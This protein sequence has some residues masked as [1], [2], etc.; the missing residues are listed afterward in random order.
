MGAVYRHAL[1]L[2]DGRRIAVI[3]LV[4]V[5]QVEGDGTAIVGAHRHGFFAN[6][7]DGPERTVLHAKAALV[8]QEHDAIPA[9]EGRACSRVA[10]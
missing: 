5:F 7:L 4:V 10:A 1:R 3:D 2:V 9:R 8:L 6:L